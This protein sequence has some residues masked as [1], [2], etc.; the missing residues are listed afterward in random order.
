MSTPTIANEQYELVT[1]DKLTTHPANPRQGDIG[2][3]VASIEAHGFY[4][5][6]VVQRSTGRILAGNHRY[7][8]AKALAMKAV[9]V[10]YVDVDDELA[11]R[12]LVADNRTS[13]LG[14]YDDVALAEL[15]TQLAQSDGGLDG[16]GY[17]GDDL[18][19]LLGDIAR[20]DGDGSGSDGAKGDHGQLQQRFLVPPFTVLDARQGYWQKRK[21]AWLALGIASEVGR[22]EALLGGGLP[23]KDKIESEAG[24]WLKGEQAKKRKGNG[25]AKAGVGN[26]NDAVLGKPK[27]QRVGASGAQAKTDPDTGKLVYETTTGATSIFDP[28]LCELAYRWFAPAGGVVLDPFAGGSVRGIVAGRLGHPYHGIDLRSEQVA[29]NREQWQAIGGGAAPTWYEG[30]SN[31]VLDDK[32][33]GLPTAADL[34]FTCPPYADLEVYSDDPADL[35]N[36]P[37]EQ[38]R[39]LYGSIIAK[40]CARLAEHRFA[41]IV[42]GDVRDPKGRYRN[43]VG[44]TVQAFEDAGLALYNEA[45]LVTPVGS[46]PVRAGKAFTAS[47]KLGKGHQNV[48]VFVKGDPKKAHAAC[49]TIEVPAEAL[50]EAEHD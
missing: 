32:K 7:L 38:F 11:H 49:G 21:R 37:Y 43:F 35:S 4:G 5:A 17:D 13:D 6:L 2:A 23:K 46:L 28:V 30:D 3:V 8:A 1:L 31:V 12:I 24:D 40:A 48:L 42:V 18:D 44:H 19:A 25:L 16:T 26:A 36:M 29:A 34:V 41:M 15:L 47:R 39:E 14:T 50:P 20:E 22:G 33:A 27:K 45:V 10:T 9:P